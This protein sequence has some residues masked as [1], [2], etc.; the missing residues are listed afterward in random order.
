M[1]TSYTLVFLTLLTLVL[2]APYLLFSFIETSSSVS[3]PSFSLSAPSLLL[4]SCC[5]Q[6]S[7]FMTST[8]LLLENLTSL[9][10]QVLPSYF[11]DKNQTV[12]Q[13]LQPNCLVLPQK[14]HT[15]IDWCHCTFIRIDQPQW[16][17][18]YTVAVLC[19]N[20]GEH[21]LPTHLHLGLIL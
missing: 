13:C 5:S 6:A 18:Q 16:N 7:W 12:D 2:L 19:L 14:N 15:T 11:P 9:S 21:S 17:P 3:F 8:I 20:Y 4:P 10:R 1:Q